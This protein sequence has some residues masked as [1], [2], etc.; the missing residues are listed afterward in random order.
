M[1]DINIYNIIGIGVLG[2]LIAYDFQPIQATKQKFIK[3]FSFFTFFSQQLDIL[4]NCS[5]CLSFWLALF[6]Y[7]DLPLG[8]LGGFVGFLINYIND[9]IKFWYDG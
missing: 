1:I 6:L 2:N 8:A 5:K 7:Q 4:L 9:K 3:L